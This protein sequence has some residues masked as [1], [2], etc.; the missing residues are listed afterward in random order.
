MEHIKVLQNVSFFLAALLHLLIFLFFSYVWLHQATRQ[1]TK[2]TYIPSYAYKESHQQSAE[3]KLTK[4]NI[5][6]PEVIKKDV[7]TSQYGIEK[8]VLDPKQVHF[9]QVVDI[10]SKH[11]TEPVHLIGDTSKT[12]QPFWEWTRL[13]PVQRAHPVKS[14]TRAES[15]SLGG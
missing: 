14:T 15:S 11:S 2:D 7:P 10:T 6:T 13:A 8:P 9:N 1:E 12:P 5:P 4:K 3:Q